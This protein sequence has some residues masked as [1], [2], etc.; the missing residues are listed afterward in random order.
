M[1]TNLPCS[2]PVYSK[3]GNTQKHTYTC[4]PQNNPKKC[5]L[6]FKRV[7]SKW[8]VNKK[9]HS[10]FCVFSNQKNLAVYTQQAAPFA[11]TNL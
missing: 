7:N 3:I 6:I 4:I 5:K 11:C 8:T 9:V 1:V 2:F 10:K